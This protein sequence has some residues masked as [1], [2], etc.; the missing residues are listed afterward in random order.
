MNTTQKKIIGA[1]IKEGLVTRESAL[2]RAMAEKAEEVMIKDMVSPPTYNLPWV[3]IVALG[4]VALG[5]AVAGLIYL[6]AN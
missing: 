2:T 4:F 5:V 6:I 1:W 3:W